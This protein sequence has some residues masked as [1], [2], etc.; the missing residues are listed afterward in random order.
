MTATGMPSRNTVLVG[1]GSPWQIT[2][3]GSSRKSEEASWRT[4][5]MAMNLRSWV[6]SVNPTSAGTSPG[7]KSN[8]SYPPSVPR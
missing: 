2:A 6:W 4:L 3:D 7:M 1:E 8:T 5:M